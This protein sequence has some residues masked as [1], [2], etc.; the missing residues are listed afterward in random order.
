MYRFAVVA[1]VA[2]ALVVVLGGTT[3]AQGTDRHSNPVIGTW[4]LNLA[5]TKS[6]AEES[7]GHD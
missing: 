7:N 3:L 2:V 5:K 1:V 6:N 4:K